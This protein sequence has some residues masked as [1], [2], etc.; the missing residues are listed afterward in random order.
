MNC[1]SH[2]HNYYL[3]ILANLGIFGFI[4]FLL[5]FLIFFIKTFIKNILKIQI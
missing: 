1:G 5:Y 2:P 3:E 4:L